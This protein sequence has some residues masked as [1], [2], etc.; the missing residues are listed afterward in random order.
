MSTPFAAWLERHRRSLVF[1]AILLAIGGIYSGLGL[2]TSLFPQAVFPRL[3]V[4]LSAGDLPAKRM[5]LRVTRPAALAVRSIPG[6]TDIHSITSRGATEIIADFKWGTDI[7]RK[8]LQAEGAIS[9]ILSKLPRDATFDVQR[10]EVTLYPVVSYSLTSRTESPVALRNLARFTLRPLLASIPGVAHIG[11]QGGQ[12]AEYHV[13]V[14]PAR[15]LAMGVTFQ[16]VSKAL[17]AQNIFN[18]I[19]R[20]AD[21]YQL[22]LTVANSRLESIQDIGNVVVK[23]GADGIVRL[24]DVAEIKPSVVPR[25]V[26]VRADGRPAVL[27]NVFQQPGG[28][29]LGIDK[30]VMAKLAAN[31]DK[32]PPD[33]TMHQWYNQSNLVAAAAGSVRDALIIG[34]VLAALVLLIFLR[35]WKVAVIACIAVPVVLAITVLLLKIFGQG[36]NIMTLGGMAA[37]IGLF[38]DDVV[39]IVEHMVRRV[40][41]AGNHAPKTLFGAVREFTSPLMG[42]SLSTILIFAPLAF[43][44]GVTGAFFQALSLTMASGLVISFFVAWL[45]VPTLASWFM[46][47]KDAGMDRDGII[48]RPFKRYYQRG[49]ARI[50]RQPGWLL[51]GLIPL[52]AVGYVGYKQVGSGFLPPMDEGGFVLDFRSPAGASLIESKRLLAKASKIITADP[53][54][55]TWSLRIG[56]QLGGGITE[57][58][59]GDYFIRLKPLPR[60]S[61][62]KVMARIRLKLNQ[63]VPALNIDTGQLTQDIIGDLTSR[64]QPVVIKLLGNSGKQLLALAPKIGKRISKIRGIVEV[65]DGVVIAGSRLDVNISRSRAA[66]KGMTPAAVGAQLKAYLHGI[67]ATQV[68]KGI[69]FIGIRVWVPHHLR[70]TTE[71]VS[72][73]LIRAPGGKLF[74]LSEVATVKEITGQP[75]ITRE[76]L[77]RTVVVSSR[78]SGRDLGSTIAAV[79][80]ALNQPGVLPKGVSY[81]LGGLY[82]QQQIAFH[83]LMMVFI[84]ALAL[85]FLLVLFLYEHFRVAVTI[86]IQPLLAVLAVFFGLWI[87]GTQLNITAM[88]GLTMIIGIVTEVAI[89]YFSEFYELES[90]MPFRQ[91]VIQAGVN[92]ARPIALTTLAF[93]L[94]LIPLALNIGSGAAM[95]KPLAI[96]IIFGLLAQFPLVLI[97][98]PALYYLFSPRAVKNGEA[99]SPQ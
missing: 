64:P 92:R 24:S 6:V 99:A 90:T 32:L 60:A 76:N 70:A 56:T 69:R 53:A 11:V 97:L 88:M 63:K 18:S 65:R 33:V 45:I 50:V 17:A 14:N 48:A 16:Q 13:N 59:R 57:A 94:A 8:K 40:R 52:V 49:M 19:G 36:F 22:Y 68:Q 23:H 15:L 75:Q 82:R 83:G 96:A 72:G 10:M 39:V 38:I 42:S 25:W 2:P 71:Q 55:E 4:S 58:N 95:L 20:L 67:V 73:L 74:P 37:A 35:S 31:T 29:T 54:V 51:L 5:E 91:A 7:V 12:I 9:R 85:V 81:E 86:I 27:V 66:L 98:M 89:F 46:R 84:A 78:I 44:G 26:S 62:E 80:T 77:K 21:H 28:S 41:E 87:T 47:A 1:L 34:V 43:L 61:I 3:R 93:I 30:A 79:K